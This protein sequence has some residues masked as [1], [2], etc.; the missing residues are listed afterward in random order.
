MRQRLCE[1][2]SFTEDFTLPCCCNRALAREFMHWALD[3]PEKGLDRISRKGALITRGACIGGAAVCPMTGGEEKQ[4]AILWWDS[5]TSRSLRCRIWVRAGGT[6]LGHSWF[7]SVFQQWLKYLSMPENVQGLLQLVRTENY[8]D[9]FGSG[10]K[11][12]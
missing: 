5:S 10:Q 4:C 7:L 1:Q 6:G 3:W 9:T 12:E 8:Q 2:L 11:K